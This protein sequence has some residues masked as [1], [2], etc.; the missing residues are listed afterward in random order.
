MTFRPEHIDNNGWLYVK[1]AV[2]SLYDRLR[3]AHELE[4]YRTT[5]SDVHTYC[6][7]VGYPRSGHSVVGSVIDA[8][9]DAIMAHRLDSLRYVARGFDEHA[10]FYMMLQNSRR[11]AATG[12]TLTGYA[13]HVPDQWQG[14]F[15]T[16]RLVGDQEGNRSSVSLGKNPAMLDRI[17]ERG[18]VRVKLVH[19][20][21]N[22]FD[23]ITT[24]ARR[25][26]CSIERS[27]RDYFVLCDHVA[28]IRARF[29]PETLIEI[30]HEDFVTAF[31]SECARLFAHLDLP[32]TERFVQDCAKMIYP[33]P[34]ATR[35]RE[36]WSPA[37]L[38]EARARMGDHPFLAGYELEV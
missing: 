5:F 36:E 1:T 3:M 37:V 8:H 10:L 32:V 16:L 28:R 23:N 2:T 27:M 17:M 22:P 26:Q 38:R 25:S 13:Y 20:I 6:V 12:R 33:R 7:F 15:R 34:R 30:R 14:R 21:R 11:Y 9:P 35:E 31:A 18:R 29:G 19:V 4:T 24:W